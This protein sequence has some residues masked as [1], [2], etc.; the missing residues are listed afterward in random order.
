[1]KSGTTN[2]IQLNWLINCRDGES[3]E[4]EHKP[5]ISPTPRA[6]DGHANGG[7]SNGDK[8][9]YEASRSRVVGVYLWERSGK[10][11]SP[12]SLFELARNHKSGQCTEGYC[13][14]SKSPWLRYSECRLKLPL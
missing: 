14:R 2:Q 13:S 10:G 7:N 8:R 5:G 11:L 1:M 9:Q 12:R 6:D 4:A 3:D